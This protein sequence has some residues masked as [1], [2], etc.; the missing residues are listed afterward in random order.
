MAPLIDTSRTIQSVRDF[1]FTSTQ[2]VCK[3]PTVQKFT[4]DVKVLNLEQIRTALDDRNLEKVSENTGIH[5][6]TLAAIRAGTNTNPTYATLKVLS[7][8]L[9]GETVRG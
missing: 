7:D 4:E 9:C 2:C 8:Y 1:A 6:N 5:R 3:P